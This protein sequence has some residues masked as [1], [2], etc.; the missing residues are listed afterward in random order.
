[1]EDDDEK[2]RPVPAK[3]SLLPIPGHE[4]IEEIAR[5]GMG[6]VYRARQLDPPRTVALKMLLPHQLG[7]RQ[8]AERFRVEAQALA[9]LDHP[10]ILPVHHFGEHD[11]MPFFTMKFA[12]GGT[13]AQ[14]KARFAGDWKGIAEL[15]AS[16]ADAVQFAHERGVLHR[17]LKPGNVLFDEAGRAYLSDFGLAKLINSDTDLT[18][19]ADFLGT[20]HYVAPEI[21]AASA[22]KATPA[23]DIYALGAILYELLSGHPPFE[24]DS[25]PAL[26]RKIV[27]E[28]PKPV[29]HYALRITGSEGDAGVK[30]KA[31]NVNSVPRDL[32]VICLKCLAKEPA[33]RYATARDLG[34]DLRRWLGGHA[35]RA[36]PVTTAERLWFWARRNPALALVSATLLLALLVGG[37]LL[38]L[39]H[40]RLSH[41]IGQLP[42]PYETFLA[43][44]RERLADVRQGRRFET[45]ELI[46]RAAQHQRTPELRDEAAAALAT[47]D[48]L[49]DTNTPPIVVLP[50]H[51]AFTPDY[52]HYF[53]RSIEGGFELCEVNQT[54]AVAH[55]PAEDR[56]PT[57]KLHVSPDGRWVF[58]TAYVQYKSRTFEFW[59]VPER[60]RVFW[61]K[62]PW[63]GAGSVF[64]SE[65][66]HPHLPLATLL[67]GTNL[68]LLIDLRSGHERVIQT[69]GHEA[70]GASFHSPYYTN[71]LLVKKGSED[72]T[73]VETNAWTVV[74]RGTSAELGNW[75]GSEGRTE[76]AR[77]DAG[78]F[79]IFDATTREVF[80]T[81][82]GLEKPPGAYAYHPDGRLLMARI[83][84]GSHLWDTLSGKLLLTAPFGGAAFLKDGR[85]AMDTPTGLI[86][87]GRLAESPVFRELRGDAVGYEPVY[88]IVASSAGRFL[89]T[90]S[91][92]GIIRFWDTRAGREVGHLEF[93]QR[94]KQDPALRLGKQDT[95]LLYSATG[96]GVFHRSLEWK[97]TSL[98]G[99]SAPVLGPEQHVLS[100]ATRVVALSTN[101]R[102]WLVHRTQNQVEV[103]DTAETGN[104]RLVL[105]MPSWGTEVASDDFHWAASTCKAKG[106]CVVWD[107]KTGKEAA[108]FSDDPNHPYVWMQFSPD[109]RWLVTGAEDRFR[110][111]RTGSWRR[112]PALDG[113][114]GPAGYSVAR[115]SGD[116]RLLVTCYGGD[117]ITLWE[118]P[119]FRRLVRLRPPWPLDAKNH[120][121]SHDGDRVWL[122]GTGHRVYEW[123]ITALRTEL[124]KLGLDWEDE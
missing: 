5:G 25:I 100:T 120:V 95:T 44:A 74:A 70:M 71:L 79:S 19:S 111:W 89:V 47:P 17:D 55:F 23:S 96:R 83:G 2:V 60:R 116:C 9:G 58:T 123:N 92:N 24:A 104:P 43:Q 10:A 13:L 80:S 122:V 8:V 114:A 98:D 88:S 108:R 59:L 31:K 35:I 110:V 33:R 75:A 37:T 41:A 106:A 45:L 16:L 76:Q 99:P 97:Q 29:T 67:I 87:M 26:L 84:A 3:G 78:R 91:E 102:W 103:W 115:F 28:Q 50:G 56:E 14:R 32:E 124:A 82:S 77:Y 51:L 53:R 81:I 4:V 107:V 66:F 72:V 20:P 117:D 94:T 40:R 65:H 49:V 36:R 93:Q 109:G 38:A 15:L 48:L 42:R 68:P 7:L 34:N 85:L 69:P 90:A 119:S 54:N 1:M 18:R 57:D 62:V 86:R 27:E 6:I 39:T 61:R 73:I 30:R 64:A 22:R 52:Q 121:V 63:Q 118:V 101:N 112:G 21:A 105:T 12:A 11:G 46:R 113:V